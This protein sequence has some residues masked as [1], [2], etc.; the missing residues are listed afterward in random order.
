MFAAIPRELIFFSTATNLFDMKSWQEGISSP[1]RVN[2]NKM[3]CHCPYCP[4]TAVANS[5]CDKNHCNLK[6]MLRHCDKSNSIQSGVLLR[7]LSP[8]VPVNM[9]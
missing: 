3:V 4:A 8:A 1:E 9:R 6:M 7:I 5:N 2:P